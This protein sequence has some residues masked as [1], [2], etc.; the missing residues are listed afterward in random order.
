[1]LVCWE[2]AEGEIAGR[3]VVLPVMARIVGDVHLAILADVTGGIDL[4]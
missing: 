4:E 3:E 1:V 2:A